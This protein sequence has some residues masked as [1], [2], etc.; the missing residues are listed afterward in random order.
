MRVYAEKH[1]PKFSVHQINEIKKFIN[2]YAPVSET[3]GDIIIYMDLILQK[4][5]NEV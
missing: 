5:S 1:K 3:R 4:N 2:Q